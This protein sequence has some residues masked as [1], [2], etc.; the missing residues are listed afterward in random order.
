MG[1][2]FLPGEAT[3]EFMAHVS[4]TKIYILCSDHELHVP[5]LSCTRNNDMIGNSNMHT[6]HA[7]STPAACGST[8]TIY[9]V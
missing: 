7:Q 5:V 9:T 4:H 2:K 1:L 6:F 3:K 8:F